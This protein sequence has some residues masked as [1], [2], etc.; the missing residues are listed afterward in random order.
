MIKITGIDNVLRNL[1]TVGGR[2]RQAA[3]EAVKDEVNQVSS[4]ARSAV[5]VRTG[6]LKRSHR[7]RVDVNRDGVHGQV[8][9]G[10]GAPYAAPVNRR[11]GFFE[12]A[13]SSGRF[14]KRIEKAVRN[15]VN[16]R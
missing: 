12:D 10:K 7:E 4:E 16:R 15:A 6:R 5:P 1:R 14:R 2:V 8:G 11:T 13:V 9:F 3:R